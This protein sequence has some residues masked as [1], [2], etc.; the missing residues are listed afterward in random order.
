MKKVSLAVLFFILAAAGYGETD[1]KLEPVTFEKVKMEDNFWLPRLKRQKDILVPFALKNTEPA[2]ENLRRVGK[3][4]K[5]GRCDTLLNL[6][7]YVA[8]DLFK[9]ME[10]VASLLSLERDARL[11]QMMDSLID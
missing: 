1:K 9:V 8:S 4:L 2:V 3:Y 10:G 5:T 7:R 6:P 11:E